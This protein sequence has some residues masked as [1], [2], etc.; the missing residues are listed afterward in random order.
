MFRR[1][2]ENRDQRE[3]IYVLANNSGYRGERTNDVRRTKVG[4][5]DGR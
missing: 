1:C 4:F 3:K 2:V 5:L